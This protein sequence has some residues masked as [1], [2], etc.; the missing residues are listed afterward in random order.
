MLC[1]PPHYRTNFDLSWGQPPRS[2]KYSRAGAFLYFIENK[3]VYFVFG[4]DSRTHQLSDFGGRKN[5][6][7]HH[8]STTVSRELFEESAMVY[9]VDTS[10]I[11]ASNVVFDSFCLYAF[12]QI[13]GY[14]RRRFATDRE[15]F[16]ENM[17]SITNPNFRESED[18]E[19]LEYSEVIEKLQASIE[20][21]SKELWGYISHYFSSGKNWPTEL[22][23][24]GG[25]KLRGTQLG[26][27]VPKPLGLV[28]TDDDGW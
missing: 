3:K 17:K 4:V 6:S 2:A 22:S 16:K 7:D 14:T 24:L 9:D 19:C 13:P 27:A 20:D 1:Y 8:W 28:Y 18:L 23:L 11:S 5:H 15:L 26:T 12:Y 21:E 25:E 10:L